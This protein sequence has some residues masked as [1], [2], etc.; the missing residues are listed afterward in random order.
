MRTSISD[1]NY[2]DVP[3]IMKISISDVYYTDVPSI[4]R[5]SISNVYYSDVPSI[6]KILISDLFD[7]DVPSI[8][9]TS[10]AK[11]IDT[12]AS[13]HGKNVS[14]LEKTIAMFFCPDLSWQLL[15]MQYYC[16]NITII[17]RPVKSVRDLDFYL[18]SDLLRVIHELV[19]DSSEVENVT[20]FVY[21][22]SLLTS[23]GDCSKEI[24]RRIARATEYGG[25]QEYMK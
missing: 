1:V 17:V 13:F 18:E 4:M 22:G 3:S 20:E 7:T 21:L 25:V 2:T 10:E 24:K 12:V 14:S 11:L 16:C 19:V 8:M 6:M 15:L 9:R 5:T 23:D